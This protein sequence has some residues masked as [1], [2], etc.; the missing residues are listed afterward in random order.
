MFVIEELKIEAQNSSTLATMILQFASLKQ[1]VRNSEH[2][3]LAS[4]EVMMATYKSRLSG[5]NNKLVND[6]GKQSLPVVLLEFY[7]GAV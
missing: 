2:V 1:P 6:I 3:R 7:T 4:A 5:G